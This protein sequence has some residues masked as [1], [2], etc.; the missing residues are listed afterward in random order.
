[1]RSSAEVKAN[2]HNY[3]A[4]PILILAFE[5]IDVASANIKYEIFVLVCRC[6]RITD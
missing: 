1:M 2:K 5:Q 6:L 3:L 4:P